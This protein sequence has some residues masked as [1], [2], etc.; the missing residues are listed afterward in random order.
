MKK[1][2]RGQEVLNI[3][4]NIYGVVLKTSKKKDIHLCV[5]TDDGNARIWHMPNAR[6][7][8]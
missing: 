1:F 5:M 3:V 4:A 7:V 6:L 2:P 8:A